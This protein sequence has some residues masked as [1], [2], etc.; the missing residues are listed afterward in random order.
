MACG[1]AGPS[2]AQLQSFHCDL[3]TNMKDETQEITLICWQLKHRA[4]LCL[5]TRMK[6]LHRSSHGRDRP[7]SA[8]G[9]VITNGIITPTPPA[10]RVSHVCCAAGVSPSPTH[11]HMGL[12]RGHQTWKPSQ[13]WTFTGPLRRGGH[14]KPKPLLFPTPI[15]P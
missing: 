6:Y 3:L 12:Q 15:L 5:I 11:T 10:R 4:A 7:R 2:S 14:L 9:A 8:E 13:A 1:W